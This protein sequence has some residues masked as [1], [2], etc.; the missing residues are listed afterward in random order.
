MGIIVN[1]E[2]YIPLHRVNAGNS[3]LHRLLVNES[4]IL[5]LVQT[6]EYPFGYALAL[7]QSA[8]I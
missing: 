5:A 7:V 8:N 3:H 2:D 1:D 4:D 6:A